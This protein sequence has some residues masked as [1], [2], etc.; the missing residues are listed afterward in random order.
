M[1]VLTQP[2][3]EST[4][5]DIGRDEVY[6]LLSNH[7]RRFAL[8]ALK[9]A[10]GAVELSD[11]A[12]QVAAWENGKT[13]ETITSTERHRVYTSMQQSHLPA[14]ER[15]GVIEHD[16]GTVKPSPQLERL[17]VYLDVVPETS[18]PWAQ[19]YLGLSVLA[20]GVVTMAA[21]GIFP[22]GG[23]GLVWAGLLTMLFLVSSAYHVWQSQGMRLGASD[24]PPE[25]ET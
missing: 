15:A 6:G 19:Y 22:A 7:R 18:I 8:H 16:N 14:M 21:I 3:E 11:L 10:E 25:V 5:G 17:E 12:E 9:D 20:A 4:D 24:V 23:S 2:V 13:V 1:S